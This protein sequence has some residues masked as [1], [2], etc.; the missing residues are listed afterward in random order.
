[1]SDSITLPR[2][3]LSPAAWITLALLVAAA[4]WDASALDLPLARLAGS[5]EGF[6]WRDSWLLAGLLHEGGRRLSWL[7]ALGLCLGVW[8]PIGPLERLSLSGRV[9]LAVTTLVAA[10]VVS[11]MKAGSAT[12]CP[13]D[14]GEFGGA[15]RYVSHWSLLPDGGSGH[16]FPAG[17][18]SSA[19]SLVGGYFAFRRVDLPLAK[20]WLAASLASGLLLGLAQQWRGA[21]FMS[22]TLWTAVVCWCMAYLLDAAWPRQA[23]I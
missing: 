21:H 11:L 15:A 10:L 19:F 6:A 14:L 7:L 13:W 20:A 4:A 3:Q 2:R 5:A 12:S 9:Q 23:G 8:W 1:M 17:H 16:C 18:A 22:H